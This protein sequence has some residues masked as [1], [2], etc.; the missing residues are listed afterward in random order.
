MYK[1]RK[2]NHRDRKIMGILTEDLTMTEKNWETKN[3]GESD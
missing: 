3:C 2:L 1:T